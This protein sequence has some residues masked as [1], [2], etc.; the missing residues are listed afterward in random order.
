MYEDFKQVNWNDLKRHHLLPNFFIRQG[1]LKYLINDPK[2]RFAM[3]SRARENF[4]E[5]S[6]D[7]YQ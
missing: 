2:N 1:V 7:L 6:R 3:I 4:D 5:I